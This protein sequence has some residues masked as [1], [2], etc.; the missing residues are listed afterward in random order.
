MEL[1][2][3]KVELDLG[4]WKSGFYEQV[5]LCQGAFV[6]VFFLDSVFA[7]AVVGSVAVAFSTLFLFAL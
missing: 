1:G 5:V 6:F 7:F 3:S 4:S 2:Y